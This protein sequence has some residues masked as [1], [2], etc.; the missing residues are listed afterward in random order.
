MFL[1]CLD[2]EDFVLTSVDA[3]DWTWTP[4]WLLVAITCTTS[5]ATGPI[6]IH[7]AC[8]RE[9]RLCIGRARRLDVSNGV[10]QKRR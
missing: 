8:L 3:R 7:A 6:P 4:S 9:G 2:C 10:V 1:D 5:A